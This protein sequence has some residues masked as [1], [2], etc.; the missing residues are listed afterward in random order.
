[1]RIL[2]VRNLMLSTTE[3]SLERL[4]TDAVRGSDDASSMSSDTSVIERVK[5]IRD[6]AFIHFRDRELALAAMHRLNGLL[7]FTFIFVNYNSFILHFSFLGQVM[8]RNGRSGCIDI[9]MIA[10]YRRTHGRNRGNGV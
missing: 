5:K 2:Y 3:E 7:K 6:Y 9:G 8:I 10:A 1:M 4:F